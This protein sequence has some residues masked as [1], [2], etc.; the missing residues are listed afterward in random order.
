VLSLILAVEKKL[1][2]RR[3][4]VSEDRKKGKRGWHQKAV[5]QGGNC[6]RNVAVGDFQIFRRGHLTTE[7]KGS[8]SK[9]RRSFWQREKQDFHLCIEGKNQRRELWDSNTSGKGE[10]SE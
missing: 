4:E 9:E 10:R 2:L 5:D 1:V 7:Q 6:A 3:K 8:R